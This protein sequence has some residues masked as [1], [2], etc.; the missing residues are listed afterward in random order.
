MIGQGHLDGDGARLNLLLVG[1]RL[2]LC[3]W[4]IG[5]GRFEGGLRRRRRRFSARDRR[6]HGERR[7]R[8]IRV[9][10]GRG[11]D[12]RPLVGDAGA[13]RRCR[14]RALFPAVRKQYGLPLPAGG[15]TYAVPP[16]TGRLVIAAGLRL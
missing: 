12:A 3:P 15:G 11:R 5:H 9:G 6:R 13:V 10:R 2:Q 16:V 14:R 4:R 8:L 1:A 7:Q